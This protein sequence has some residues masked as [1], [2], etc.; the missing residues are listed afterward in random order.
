MVFY[1]S[2]AIHFLHF[3]IARNAAAVLGAVYISRVLCGFGQLHSTHF[4]VSDRP[5]M[6]VDVQFS[7]ETGGMKKNETF[8]AQYLAHGFLL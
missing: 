3:F 2:G 6:R 5:D 1:S 8:P 4:W 7:P